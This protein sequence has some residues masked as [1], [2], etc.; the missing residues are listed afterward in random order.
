[1][2]KN[3]EQI[4]PR[5]CNILQ[6]LEYC[7]LGRAAELLNCDITDITH[8]GIT[9]RV[10]VYIL[11]KDNPTSLVFFPKITNAYPHHQYLY[12]NDCFVFD[13]HTY[14]R[15]FSVGS[16][17]LRDD[18]IE[19][20]KAQEGFRAELYGLW[21]LPPYIVADIENNMLPDK[22]DL[23]IRIS[24]ETLEED[25]AYTDLSEWSYIPTLND[26]YIKK[27]DMVRLYES[28]TQENNEIPLLKKTKSSSEQEIESKPSTEA[29]HHVTVKQSEAIVDALI[30]AGIKDE[31]FKGS[32]EALQN[33]LS[34]MGSNKLAKVD[35]NTLSNWLSR[36][37]VR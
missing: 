21:K 16:I 8:F 37:G 10:N 18:G 2:T 9:A 27:I 11:L 4:V 34:S 23:V 24:A 5:N 30:I 35:K 14:M 32:I 12:K 26:C 1:M 28:F 7:R 25:F 17:E 33:K 6:Q 19:I 36:A 3:F 31:D 15:P 29:K 20:P 13:E 22:E